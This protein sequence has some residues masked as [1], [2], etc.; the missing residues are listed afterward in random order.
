[1][2]VSK[3]SSQSV[4]SLNQLNPSKWWMYGKRWWQQFS[5][6]NSDCWELSLELVPQSSAF[7]QCLSKYQPVSIASFLK[8]QRFRHKMNFLTLYMGCLQA[9]GLRSPGSSWLV[10][11]SSPNFPTRLSYCRPS[12][13]PHQ[14]HHQLEKTTNF[15]Y[16]WGW[17]ISFHRE[18]PLRAVSFVDFTA[19][20]FTW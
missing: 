4:A 6:H 19:R 8:T 7:S 16:F 3:S 15:I 1:M 20:C 18:L 10:S 11:C 5:A 12:L 9:T 14:T 13:C 2:V 17:F